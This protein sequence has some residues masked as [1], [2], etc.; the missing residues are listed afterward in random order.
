MFSL[1]YSTILTMTQV[2][3]AGFGVAWVIWALTLICRNGAQSVDSLSHEFMAVFFWPLALAGLSILLIIGPFFAFLDA[4]E[5]E[6]V[7]KL[8]N[9]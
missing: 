3:L 8:D 9:H 1:G 5:L 2:Y 4:R 6:K 7:R